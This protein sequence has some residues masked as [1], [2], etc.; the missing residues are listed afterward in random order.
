VGGVT[1]AVA[2]RPDL[3]MQAIR[4]LFAF[5]RRGWWRR[6]PFVPVPD[7]G[8]MAFRRFTAYGSVDHPLEE[9]DVIAFL[10]WRR[11]AGL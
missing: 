11:E 6:F 10:E 1:R 8:Y 2:R 3:W 5:A 7:P 4:S 9:R